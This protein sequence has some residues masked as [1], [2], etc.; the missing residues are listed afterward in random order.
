MSQEEF[1]MYLTI[2]LIVVIPI[3]VRLY[4]YLTITRVKR[5]IREQLQRQEPHQASDSSK[6]Q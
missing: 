4:R 5:Q 1:F 6:P 2:G 3:S